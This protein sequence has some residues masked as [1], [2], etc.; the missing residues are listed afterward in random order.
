LKSAPESETTV[1]PVVPPSG[2]KILAFN[3][4]GSPEVTPKTLTKSNSTL[5][6]TAYL[7]RA[8]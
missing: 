3:T 4:T 8:K 1:E 5:L 2:I 6:S 7:A